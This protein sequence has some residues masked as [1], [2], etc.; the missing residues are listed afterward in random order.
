MSAHPGEKVD[1]Y[2]GNRNLGEPVNRFAIGDLGF[3]THCL[4]RVRRESH[5]RF[6]G[7]RELATAS[8]YP[9]N[10]RIGLRHERVCPYNSLAPSKGYKIKRRNSIHALH[11]KLVDLSLTTAAVLVKE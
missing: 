1:A 6:Y 3:Q 7:G 2:L 4:S 10:Y 11:S 9:P 8:G 5:A